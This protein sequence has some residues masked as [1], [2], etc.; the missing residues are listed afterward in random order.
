MAVGLACSQQ[1]LGGKP[2]VKQFSSVQKLE[3]LFPAYPPFVSQ[4]NERNKPN[5]K[6]G[7]TEWNEYFEKHCHSVRKYFGL[8]K[9]RNE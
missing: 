9:L 7:N 5:S 8:M 6:G 2:F 1:L 4:L 3:H